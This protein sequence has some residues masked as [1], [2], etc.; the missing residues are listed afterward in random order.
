MSISD[1]DLYKKHDTLVEFNKQTYEKIFQRCINEIKMASNTGELIYV[2]QIPQ[3]LIGHGSL[4]VNIIP[5]AN[6]IIYRMNQ[7]NSNIR[8][9][10]IE[11]N[12]IL[13]DWRRECDLP[14][15]P[16]YQKNQ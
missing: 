7:V 10:F 3:T 4:F 1:R 15:N 14:R 5:C 16:D 9:T 2:F 6:Y 12:L 8:T 11:P 13:F